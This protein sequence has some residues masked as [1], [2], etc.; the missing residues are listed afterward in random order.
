MIAGSASLA[1]FA[2]AHNRR[3]V[4]AL[5]A[6]MTATLYGFLLK[7]IT[8]AHFAWDA[9]ALSVFGLPLFAYL[10]LRSKLSYGSGN[11]SWKGRTY[12]SSRDTSSPVQPSLGADP[13]TARTNF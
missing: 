5:A 1:V 12:G 3:W 2:Y 13:R 7:R 8:R 10:L 11:V 9:N 4:A 6:L